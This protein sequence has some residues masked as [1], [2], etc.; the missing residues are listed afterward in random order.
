MDLSKLSDGDLD[1]LST[2]NLAGLSD[3]G[4]GHLEDASRPPPDTTSMAGRFWQGV[5]DPIN[6]GAQLLSKA[7]PDGVA[8]AIDN[9]SNSMGSNIPAGGVDEQVR[10]D[11]KKYQAS[12][13]DQA[14]KFDAWRLAGNILNPATLA[15]GASSMPALGAG[16]LARMGIGAAAGA[17]SAALSPVTEGDP[18]NFASDKLKQGALG[19]VFGAGVVPI[20]AG[21]SRV[22]NP[23]AVSNPQLKTLLD[24]GVRP[25]V[26]QTLGGVANSIE[27]KAM[28]WPIVG[29]AIANTRRS[30]Q[31]DFENAAINRSQAPLGKTV[32]GVGHGAVSDARDNINMAYNDAKSQLG[33][34]VPDAQFHTDLGQLRQMATGLT[35]PL[36]RQFNTT[37]DNLIT[38]KLSPAGGMT[39]E[40]FKGADSELGALAAKYKNAPNQS[41]RDFGDSLMQAQN[42]LTQAATRSNPAAA[43]SFAKAD[44]AYANLVRIENA[45][46]RG[47]NDGG[48]FTPAQLNQ[49]VRATD[50]SVRHNQSARGDALMQ[51]FSGA[52]QAIL[53]GTVPDSGTAGR[54]TLA[55]V[56]LGLGAAHLGI[57]A[58]LLG[59]ATMYTRPMQALVRGSIMTRPQNAQQIAGALTRAAPALAPAASLG[60][61]DMLEH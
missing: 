33:A 47:I 49:A 50:R 12:R 5:K 51:D 54:A 36:Q 13:G 3:E 9:A 23:A 1:H 37:I 32:N 21:L 59:G 6:G 30:A 15:M 26:G 17:G 19:A 43:A 45:A 27:Q 25:S 24:A 53:G 29:D 48:R 4:L 7:V 11:E 20:A 44:Q 14:G 60:G 56:G 42:L 31:A 58:A 41:A 52:G 16:I 61:L 34:F 40:T 46:N 57:P 18:S 10:S 22:V 28:S 8:K 39:S 55:A 38:G 35:P 2:G